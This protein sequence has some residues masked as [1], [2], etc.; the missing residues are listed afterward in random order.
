[1]SLGHPLHT[2]VIGAGIG[3]LTTAALLLKAGHRVTVLEA[4]IY[5]GGSA[6]TFFHKGY[7]FDA[8]ATLA[9]GFQ[10][11]G[12]HARV[13]EILGLQWQNRPVDPAWVVHLPGNQIVQWAD[14][15]QWREE[16]QR[17]F[18][19]SES[20]WLLQEHLAEVSW[21][22]SSRHFPY[23]PS[24][25]RDWIALVAA[26][27]PNLISA[28]PFAF[29]K[30]S[31]LLPRSTNSELRTFLDA[32]LMISAQTHAG[33]A[34]ALYG[35][36]ALDLPRRGVNY[37]QGG[38]GSLAKTL[39]D[40]IKTNGGDILYRQEVKRLH[41][42][43]GRVVGLSTN[44]GLDLAG[45]LFVGNLTPWGLFNLL[46]QDAPPSLAKEIT[47]RKPTW[48]GFVLYLGLQADQLPRG[49]A[50][51]HQVVVDPLRPLGEGN[52]VFISLSPTSDPQ[53]APAG[54]R[55]A[56]LSTH[57]VIAPWWQLRENDPDGYTR[58][59]EEYTRR[60][61]HAAEMAIPG[62]QSAVRF[63]LP[64]TPVS[65][66]YFTS[67]PQG[68]VGGFPQSSLFQVRGPSTGIP[69]LWLVGDSIFPGQST[70]GVTIGAMRVA[71]SILQ[72]DRPFLLAGWQRRTGANRID[73]VSSG[74]QKPYSAG[75]TAPQ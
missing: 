20:F 38:I 21:G 51:H 55:A 7:R 44:K 40:W 35:S 15:H 54:M 66:Q 41:V 58:R 5:P 14:P 39:A 12:P 65:F 63:I 72:Q 67:R 61:L 71:T 74:K 43:N 59:K 19:G 6:G 60:V 70:A 24:S 57:T 36:A 32:Q 11:G 22:L 27:H 33:N 17:I 62:F 45:D 29:S 53:R 75:M 16:R 47:R 31:D 1:M 42:K 25:T 64:G 30:V 68:M 23:P 37:F 2:I 26:F 4:H 8:G 3:G 49:I 18:P 52:S 69:N 73:T 48:G 56:T 9:G 50:N 10:P 34:N 13:A 46:G 28:V